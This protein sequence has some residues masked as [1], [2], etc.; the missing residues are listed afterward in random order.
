[1]S[2]V[3]GYSGWR[4]IFIVEGLI[5]IVAAACGKFFIVNWPEKAKFLNSDER[6]L[7]SRRLQRD[8]PEGKMDRLDKKA[9]T[10]I[11]YDWKIYIGFVPPQK[12]FH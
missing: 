3:G 5:T 2:G 8:N 10:R 4:W 12:G 6:Q 7:L 9:R 11:L 1:M